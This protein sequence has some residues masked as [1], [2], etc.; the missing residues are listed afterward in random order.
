LALLRLKDAWNA[1]IDINKRPYWLALSGKAMDVLDVNMAIRVYR[2][3]GDAGMVLGLERIKPFED[4]N[5][6]AGHILLLFQDYDAAQDLFLAS[7]QPL[8]A[9]DMRRDLLHWEQAL[10]LA[11]SLDPPFP[12]PMPNN[13]NSRASTTPL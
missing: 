11:H 13:W 10:K 9:L 5:L 6:L 7:T 2:Q 4:T 8:H 1:A 12:V 3:L